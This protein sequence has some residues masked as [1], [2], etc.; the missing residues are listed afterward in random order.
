MLSIHSQDERAA[1]AAISAVRT[2]EEQEGEHRGEHPLRARC[3]PSA[4]TRPCLNG[5]DINAPRW[6]SASANFNQ[7]CELSDGRIGR[8][9][10]LPDKCDTVDEV[11]NRST[12]A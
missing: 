5:V 8:R 6:A 9:L 10:V 4:V 7:R 1:D 2:R 12:V 3:S 11:V